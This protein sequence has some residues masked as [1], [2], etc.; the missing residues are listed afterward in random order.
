MNDDWLDDGELAP[1]HMGGMSL[2]TES[3]R[4]GCP[5][6]GEVIELIVDLSQGSHEYIEDCFVCCRP[7]MVQVIDDGVDGLVSLRPEDEA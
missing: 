6:C 2:H 1:E 4:L 7:I 5:Y 3:R